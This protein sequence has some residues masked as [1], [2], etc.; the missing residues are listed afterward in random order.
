MRRSDGNFVLLSPS[1]VYVL[2]TAMPCT[3]NRS[4]AAPARQVRS[5]MARSLHLLLPEAPHPTWAPRAGGPEQSPCRARE[6]MIQLESP[7]LASHRST[8]AGLM[9]FTPWSRLRRQP[10][11]RAGARPLSCPRT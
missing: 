4:V 10:A 5:F 1:A 2:I 7:E 6:G 9:D 3:A 8:R 11:G